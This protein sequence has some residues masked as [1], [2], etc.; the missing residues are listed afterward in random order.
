MPTSMASNNDPNM[1]SARTLTAGAGGDMSSKTVQSS[2][3]QPDDI[4][5]MATAAA[6]SAGM[7]LKE[8]ASTIFGN[9][10]MVAHKHQK[11]AKITYTT[12][13]RDNKLV[14]I[15]QG[16]ASVKLATV[17]PAFWNLNRSELRCVISSVIDMSARCCQHRITLCQPGTTNRSREWCEDPNTWETNDAISSDTM[18]IDLEKLTDLDKNLVPLAER[19]ARDIVYSA[20]QRDTK[21]RCFFEKS[22]K[23]DV[24][25]A[26]CITGLLVFGV[27][28]FKPV[29]WQS[30]MATNVLKKLSPIFFP[31]RMEHESVQRTRG[32][33]VLE[34][35][36]DACSEYF[37]HGAIPMSILEEV[38]TFQQAA[39]T[40]PK[41]RYNEDKNAYECEDG[42]NVFPGIPIT[43]KKQKQQ[44]Q[45]PPTAPTIPPS[46]PPPSPPPPLLD[47][48]DYSSS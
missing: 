40:V 13:Q 18:P 38:K 36:H 14:M 43:E 19:L 30:I 47:N 26:I 12:L 5:P 44:Q 39:K 8:V 34:I 29:L 3:Q 1:A 46:S 25:F 6:A 37:G 11:L 28:T 15:V 20:Y 22:M 7:N 24:V 31:N 35:T 9:L 16:M 33:C 45:Q 17:D 27:K 23:R 32:M 10:G 21:C 48:R 41:R 4:Q 42:S 2:E